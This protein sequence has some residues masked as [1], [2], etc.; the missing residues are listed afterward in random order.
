MCFDSVFV[1]DF[2]AI[3]LSTTTYMLILQRIH[4]L[5]DITWHSKLFIEAS[6]GSNP[7]TDADALVYVP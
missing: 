1:V 2:Y 7:Q 3:Y 6:V 4:Q 5:S